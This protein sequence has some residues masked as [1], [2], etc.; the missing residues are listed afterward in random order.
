MNSVDDA[1]TGSWA[2][3]IEERTPAATATVSGAGLFTSNTTQTGAYVV[4]CEFTYGSGDY[5]NSADATITVNVDAGAVN[6]LTIVDADDHGTPTNSIILGNNNDYDVIATLTGNTT[7]QYYLADS[8]VTYNSNNLEVAV[9]TPG[10]VLETA[11]D[12]TCNDGAPAP[13]A[14]GTTTISARLGSVVS[15]NLVVTVTDA[16]VE[17]IRCRPGWVQAILDDTVNFVVEKIYSDGTTV[18]IVDGSSDAADLTFT[19]DNTTV[20]MFEPVNPPSIATA[21]GLGF[22]NITV[23]WSTFHDVCSMEVV[24]ELQTNNSCDEAFDIDPVDQVLYGTTKDAGDDSNDANLGNDV[25]YTFTLDEPATLDINVQYP[26]ASGWKIVTSVADASGSCGH[27]EYT[28]TAIDLGTA[29]DLTCLPSGTYYVVVDGEAADDLGSFEVALDFEG[30]CVPDFS[31]DS[32]VDIPDTCEAAEFIDASIISEEGI[33]GTTENAENDYLVLGGADVFYTF[34][35]E[36]AAVLTMDFSG[37]GALTYRILTTDEECGDTLVAEDAANC[38]ELD[39]GVYY[40]V[41]DSSV[42]DQEG[43]FTLGWDFDY[44]TDA[45]C[46]P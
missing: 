40:I 46:G 11:G 20:A 3:S 14:P 44:D 33:F 42:D 43:E 38:Y 45:A 8:V 5:V 12:T 36:E 34:E 22:A 1:G 31:G 9:F 19:S 28:G 23:D 21:V 25:F 16:V 7:Y 2:W 18:A 29:P 30:G 4:K 35:L 17:S 32:S 37:Q 13:C 41:V 24:E 26:A 39:A 27:G 10:G 6:T 15:N